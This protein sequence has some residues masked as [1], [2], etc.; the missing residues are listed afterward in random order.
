MYLCLVFSK[1][2]Y[3]SVKGTVLETFLVHFSIVLFYRY[4]ETKQ[5]RSFLGKFLG[6]NH[7]QILWLSDANVCEYIETFV[8]N[9]PEKMQEAMMWK[10][11]TC[12]SFLAS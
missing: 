10:E 6:L 5:L 4:G 8:I 1:A 3:V 7:L 11:V 9:G 2:E 12:E